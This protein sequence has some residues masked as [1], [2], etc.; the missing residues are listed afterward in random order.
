MYNAKKLGRSTS[1]VFNGAMQERLGTHVRMMS[2]LHLALERNELSLVYQPI[3]DLTDG[4][5]TGIEA[6]M[7][8]RHP[9]LGPIPPIDFIPVAEES[10]LIQELGRFAL[11]TACATLARLDRA[12]CPPLGVSIN[13]SVA[14]IRK[15]RVVE[16]VREALT[17]SGIAASRVTLE[18]TESGLLDSGSKVPEVL[19]ALAAL[20]VRLCID[21][22][23]TGYSSLR[24]LHEYPID[25]LKIDRSFVAGN[26]GTVANEAIVHMLL[27]L[28]RSLGIVAIAEGIE[29]DAQR[30]ALIESGCRFAQGFLFAAGLGEP[31]LVAWI[32]QR[33]ELEV[34]A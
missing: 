18:I 20:G 3:V 10:D 24:Y 30:C 17:T 15:G 5:V 25:V 23:G 16:D 13:L 11:R 2:D 31:E 12:G 14:H 22:F 32:S 28:A 1:V 8:W 6:L 34:S 4:R 7:R 33:R 9:T 19:D 21:D 27:T 29:T 26:D